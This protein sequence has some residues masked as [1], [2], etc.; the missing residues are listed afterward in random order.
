MDAPAVITVD[1]VKCPPCSGL[2]C[3]GVCP[4][5][6]LEEGKDKKPRVVDVASCTRCGVC[7][8]LCPQNAI[9]VKDRKSVKER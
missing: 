4:L 9:T 3:V 2:V 5:G 1:F 6:V 7:V 8:D